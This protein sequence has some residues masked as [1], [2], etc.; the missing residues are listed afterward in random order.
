[1][2]ELLCSIDLMH[3]S[4]GLFG[5]QHWERHLILGTRNRLWFRSKY[6]IEFLQVKTGQAN[7]R[8]SRTVTI[9]RHKMHYELRS[10]ANANEQ[11]YI[12]QTNSTSI[13]GI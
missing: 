1:M 3:I 8:I 9:N 5:S 4:Q 6:I 12:T 7:G 10:S 13:Y 2:K 11:C